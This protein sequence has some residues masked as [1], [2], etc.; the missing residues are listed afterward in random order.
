MKTLDAILKKVDKP[1]RYIGMEVGSVYKDFEDMEVTLAFAYPDVYEIGMSYTGM[2][3]IY[4]LVNSKETYLCERTFAP[5]PDMEGEMRKAGLP[6]YSLESKRPVRDFDFL[7]FTFQYELSYSNILNMIDLA[8]IEVYRKDR[9]E[10]DPIIIGGGPCTYNPEPMADFFD[11]F[12][13]GEGE[14]GLIELFDLYRDMKKKGLA[15]EAF[16]REAGQKIKGIYVPAFY[17]EVYEGQTLVGRKAGA[18]MPQT[19]GKRYIQDFDTAYANPRA[20][21]PNIQS[22]HDRVVEGIFR[23]C[24][25]GCRFCQAGMIYRPIREK[26]VDVIMDHLDAKLRSTGHSEISLSSLSTCDYSNLP[27]LIKRLMDKYREENISISLPSIRLDSKGIEVLEL[28]DS[29]RKP[30]ITFAPEAGSQ[31][32]RDVINKNISEEDLKS[33]VSYCFKHGYATIKLYFMIGLP[34][35][36]YEDLDGI[37]DLAY[38][39]KDMFYAQDKEDMKGNLSI[40]VST[41]NFVPKP[42]TPFQWVGQDDLESLDAKAAYL[43]EKLRDNKI[44]YSYHDSRTSRVEAVLAKGDRRVGRGIYRAWKQGAKFDAWSDYFDYDLWTGAFELEGIDMSYYANMAMDYDRALAWDFIDIGVTKRFLA[45]EMEKAKKE[46]TTSDCRRTCHGCG[47]NKDYPGDF[48]P[49][50]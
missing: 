44:S 5:W 27:D 34:T 28:I 29:G 42:F 19:I 4:G 43:K 16:L 18:G 49:C 2:E 21:V 47:V 38:L 22:V 33:S 50:I 30:T 12:Y 14:E 41:S 35:E 37:V 15:K 31:R 24:T 26:S 40:H 20:F 36:T 7:G 8:G 3:I 39:V 11:I 13:I 25:Q 10:E 9:D 32:L 17:E 6:L 1:A 45:R 23:G 46:E 48:C